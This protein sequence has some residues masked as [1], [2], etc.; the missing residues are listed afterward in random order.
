MLTDWA[1]VRRLGSEIQERI[2]GARVADVGSLPD[3]RVALSLWRRKASS[4]LCIDAFG[5]PPLVTLE[6]GELAAGAGSAFTRILARTLRGMVVRAV[7]PRRGDRLL[8]F[9]F[10]IR[11]RFGVSDELDL[12]VELVP[13]FGNAVLAKGENVVAALK[14]FGL[15]ENPARAVLP[16]KPYVPPPLHGEPSLPRL[17]AEA[18]APPEALAFLESD[19]ALHSPVYVYRRDGALVQVHLLP[20]PQL[21]EDGVAVNREPS[22]LDVLAQERDA[23]SDAAEKSR[24]QR[25]RAAV[26]RRIAHRMRTIER[27]LGQLQA[28]RVEVSA[29]QELRAEGQHIYATL[30]E[31]DDSHREE[32]KARAQALFERYRK[33]RGSVE[34]LDERE[35]VLRMKREALETLMWEAERAEDQELT[36][37]ETAL[38]LFDRRSAVSSP[39]KPPSR[40]KRLEFRTAAGSR[41]LVGRSPLENAELTFR[42]ARPQ[43]LW[44]HARGVPGAHVI[45]SRDDRSPPPDEDVA[46]AASLAAGYSRARES[47]R[48]VV[49]Y[50]QRKFVRKQRDAPPGMVYYTNAQSLAVARRTRI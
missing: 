2:R 8:R 14:E 32:A 6:T 29:R 26:G 10:A 33:L 5:S 3:G 16:G 15:A 25:R 30:H 48:V 24:A 28:R 17:I 39:R 34:H 13:R 23:R 19:E 21:V 42:V 44:F 7:L 46:L 20:L 41:L 37:V 4:L 45:L 12:W 40:R 18:S 1:L 11:S 31:L 9:M 43:D 35:R 47:A 49:D 22:L 27:E 50:T 36:D 38:G